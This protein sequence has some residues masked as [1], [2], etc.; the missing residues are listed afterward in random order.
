MISIIWIKYYQYL[1]H[2]I[3]QI[4][5][6]Q[7]DGKTLIKG[8]VT[9]YHLRYWHIWW[10]F[11]INLDN[12]ICFNL[13]NN[14]CL[15]VILPALQIYT[16]HNFWNGSPSL[17]FWVHCDAIF[18]FLQLKDHDRIVQTW[19]DFSEYFKLYDVKI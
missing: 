7:L 18:Q 16:I 12:V 9:P 8:I 2:I 6:I 17:I 19:N 14:L 5:N 13:A 4:H 1:C 10:Y 15:Y 11:L 3:Q